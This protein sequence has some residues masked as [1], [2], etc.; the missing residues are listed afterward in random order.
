MSIQFKHLWG[1]S[2][3]NIAGLYKL[4]G[5]IQEL[6]LDFFSKGFQSEDN[7]VLHRG[8]ERDSAAQHEPQIY[9]GFFKGFDQRKLN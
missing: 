3:Q 2:V 5:S 7:I 8:A 6:D 9:S 4:Y 1:P